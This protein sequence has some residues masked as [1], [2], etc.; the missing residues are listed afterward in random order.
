VLK[1]KRIKKIGR[2]DYELLLQ[3]RDDLQSAGNQRIDSQ[4]NTFADGVGIW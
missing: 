4:T 1:V 3:F 2:D